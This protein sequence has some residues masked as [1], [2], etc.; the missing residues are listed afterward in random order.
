MAALRLLTVCGHI[1]RTPTRGTLPDT[2]PDELS[3][4]AFAGD[5]R[6]SSASAIDTPSSACRSAQMPLPLTAAVTSPLRWARSR[7]RS[8]SPW[9]PRSSGYCT[10]RASCMLASCH[11]GADQREASLCISPACPAPCCSEYMPNQ[12]IVMTTAV[13]S[14]TTNMSAVEQRDA[15]TQRNLVVHMVTCSAVDGMTS[16]RKSLSSREHL[17]D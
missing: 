11:T 4:S 13:V 16:E 2:R 10:T 8:W 1:L 7:P 12:R 9:L 15:T 5:K 14:Y 3:V 17:T 6:R